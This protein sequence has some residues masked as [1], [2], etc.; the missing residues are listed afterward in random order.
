MDK[1]A[2]I[3]AYVTKN[4][5]GRHARGHIDLA[6]IQARAEAAW[7]ESQDPHAQ[8]VIKLAKKGNYWTST[9]GSKKRVYFDMIRVGNVDAKGY[10]DIAARS[11]VCTSV[12]ADVFSTAV[13]STI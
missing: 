7:E 4:T 10:Y 8:F 3:A 9:D 12:A 6:A 2:F 13:L 5:T 11:W 1:Q